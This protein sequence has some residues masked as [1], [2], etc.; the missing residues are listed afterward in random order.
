MVVPA[1]NE[2]DRLPRMLRECLAYLESRRREK[3]DC[4]SD[5]TSGLGHEWS[6]RHGADAVRVLTLARNRGKGGAVRAG[7]LRARGEHVLFADADGATKFADLEKLEERMAE[8]EEGGLGVVCGSRAHLE[9]DSIGERVQSTFG[10][11]FFL[12]LFSLNSPEIPVP[13]YPDVRLPHLRLPLR[14]QDHQRHTVRLQAALQK[15]EGTDQSLFPTS[16][17]NRIF[18]PPCRP[19]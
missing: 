2:E 6:A 3:R 13:Y 7:A 17:S 4:S 1:Y 5:A 14:Y 9:K 8:V 12:A 18:S 11:V 15:C 19:P 10:F 16:F